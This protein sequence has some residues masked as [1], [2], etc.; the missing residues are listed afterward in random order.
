[1]SRT[2][3]NARDRAHGPA[4][5]FTLIE[6]MIVV[7]IVGVVVRIALLNMG[8]FVP[9]TI[10][11]GECKQMRAH[12]DFLRSEAR[13]RSQWCALELDLDNHRYRYVLAP[14]R[15][16]A[17]YEEDVKELPLSWTPLDDRARFAGVAVPSRPAIEH[18]IYRITF[19]ENG[20]TGDIAIF[21]KLPDEQ[22]EYMWTLQLRGLTGRTDI[23]KS[24]EGKRF[25]LEELNE[26][27][28]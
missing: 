8:A 18:G 5:G 16:L 21:F 1:M 13:L 17:S 3:D 20:S 24:V 27:A 22:N 14:E 26:S 23:R 19:D 25:L 28:F 9:A 7:A 12:L 11:N 15:K 2:R 4:G 6:L 10:L